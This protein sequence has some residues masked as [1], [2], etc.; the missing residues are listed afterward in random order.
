MG[1]WLP[2]ALAWLT[3]APCAA[4]QAPHTYVYDD[5]IS[6]TAPGGCDGRFAID[7]NAFALGNWVVP[8][9]AGNPSGLAPNNPAGY[10]TMMG[11]AVHAQFWGRDS[12]A[13]GSFLSSGLHFVQGP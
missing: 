13:T 2:L 10:L 8:D 9:C 1:R 12:V 5:G 3:A 7:M 11:Q 4:A 6:D